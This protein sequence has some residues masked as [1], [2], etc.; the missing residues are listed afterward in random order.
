M[1]RLAEEDREICLFF[2]LLLYENSHSIDQ[3]TIKKQIQNHKRSTEITT[4]TDYDNEATNEEDTN[5][6]TQR[7]REKKK[8]HRLTARLET[9]KSIGR[10]LFSFIAFT[11]RL[12]IYLV[13]INL[14]DRILLQAMK[15]PNLWILL[16][17]IQWKIAYFVHIQLFRIFII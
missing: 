6:D 1:T 12:W 10:F 11:L 16:C 2:H 9:Y 7:A 14:I 5:W 8:A 13:S 4:A 15:I 17:W 3:C